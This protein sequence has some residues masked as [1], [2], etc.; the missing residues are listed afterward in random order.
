[1]TDI[2]NLPDE[3]SKRFVAVLNKKIETG[4]LMNALGHLT[5]GFTSHNLN[6]KEICLL[7]YKDKNEET[8]AFISHYPFII[9]KADNS[10]KIK[11]LRQEAIIK[12]ITFAD[13]TSSMSIG[14]S[15]EQLSLTKNSN[16][17]DLEYYA[18]LFFGN[19]DTLKHLTKNYSLFN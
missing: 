19:S 1:M 4:K 16:P 7:D 18:I 13:F 10:N 8:H 11:K 14:I 3:N 9:L 6:K 2:I 12:K 17:D 15:Q 5:A